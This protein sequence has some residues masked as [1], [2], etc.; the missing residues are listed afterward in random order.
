MPV[1]LDDVAIEGPVEDLNTALDLATGRLTPLGRLVVEVH[2]DGRELV[3]DE[4][5]RH[6]HVPIDQS[7]VRLYS[8]D[9]RDLVGTV[10]DECREGLDQAAE[11]QARAADLLQQDHEE[12][13][14]R[15][16]A[17]AI[18]TWLKI[19]QAVSGSIGLLRINLDQVSIEGQPAAEIVGQL[20]ER[21]GQLRDLLSD[22]DVVG[23]ADALAYEWPRSVDQWRRL[24]QHLAQIAREAGTTI[25]TED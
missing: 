2:L 21:L 17:E 15:Q 13:A 14:M 8:S 3:G 22:R 1:Y 20:A 7:E 19:Q 4:L 24:I 5:E 18:E 16:V 10:L 25:E 23:I 6:R 11:A 12:R 9:T